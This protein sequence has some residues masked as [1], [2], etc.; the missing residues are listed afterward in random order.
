VLSGSI[1]KCT[2]EPT[3]VDLRHE[4]GP[5]RSCLGTCSNGGCVGSTAGSQCEAQR[6]TG[7]S[8]GVGPLLCDKAGGSCGGDKLSP[9]DCGAYA[10]EPAFGAC[11]T[12]C[13]QSEQ[14]AQGYFCDVPTQ[15]CVGNSESGGDGGGCTFGGGEAA[16][17]FALLA[18]VA[19]VGA[20][21]RRRRAA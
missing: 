12:T 1:G 9:F 11:R 5:G 21:S 14:C 8:T 20:L 13:A 4:C 7:P 18:G 17:S 3:G 19:L 10:C 6:C 2:V 15:T 16:R